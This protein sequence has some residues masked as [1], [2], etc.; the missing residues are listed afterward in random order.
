M[1][2]EIIFNIYPNLNYVML[3]REILEAQISLDLPVNEAYSEIK[4]WLQFN[5]VSIKQENPPN[6]LVAYWKGN[7]VVSDGES[8]G[9]RLDTYINQFE[10]KVPFDYDLV[11]DPFDKEI[12]VKF[13]GD[14][15]H[16]RAVITVEQVDPRHGEKGRVYWG[17]KLE[18]MSKELGAEIKPR[19]CTAPE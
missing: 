12:K 11:N 17:L 14:D 1:S 4:I 13:L 7:I 6:N 18:K 9:Y 15:R 16:S 3:Q 8:L 5:D 10:P 19:T 2:P